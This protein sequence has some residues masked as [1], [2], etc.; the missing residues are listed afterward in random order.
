MTGL[1]YKDFLCMKK[2]MMY[3][4]ITLFV[5]FIIFAINMKN[6]TAIYFIPVFVSFIV[7]I[8]AFAYDEVSKWNSY[9][10][11][12][13]ITKKELVLSRYA[14]AALLGS[15][16]LVIDIVFTALQRQFSLK[17]FVVIYCYLAI[18]V[19][20]SALLLPILFQFG[21]QKSRILILLL[22]L[23]PMGV[24]FAFEQLGISLPA[25]QVNEST[26]EVL[27]WLSLPV[28]LILMFISYLISC[29]I[30]SRKEP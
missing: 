25:F 13:P 30:V 21:T 19:F 6:S 14:L 23:L 27:L 12:L 26:S 3:L 5:F 15:A 1:L 10:L 20:F 29:A 8:N 24:G 2:N 9:A 11:T 17:Q 28:C 16:S 4:I 18:S 7:L 22:A